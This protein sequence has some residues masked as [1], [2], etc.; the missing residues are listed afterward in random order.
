MNGLRK[1]AAPTMCWTSLRNPLVRKTAPRT[2]LEMVAN[3]ARNREFG[4]GSQAQNGQ[5]LI[6]RGL[7]D[8]AADLP[9]IRP[10]IVPR[11]RHVMRQPGAEPAL[12]R[13]VV[14]RRGRLAQ[15]WRP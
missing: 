8:E 11:F 2:A 12:R 7:L 4:R 6:N 14:R 5:H 10:E 15:G 13:L 3:L 1:A 9:V